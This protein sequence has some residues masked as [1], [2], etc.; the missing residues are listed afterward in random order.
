MEVAALNGHRPTSSAVPAARRCAVKMLAM[1]LLIFFVANSEIGADELA[2]PFELEPAQSAI[3]LKGSVNGKPILLI[4]DTGASRTILALEIARVPSLSMS[5]FAE[6]GPGLAVRGRYAQATLELGGRLWR[7]RIVVGMNLDEVS[8]AYGRR[9][10]GL[11]GQDFLKEFERVT[12][13]FRGRRLLLG[14]GGP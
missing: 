5:R 9:I 1:G 12:I 14:S 7:D 3:L 4:L 13:D 2:L 10:D 6:S 11:L 8:K